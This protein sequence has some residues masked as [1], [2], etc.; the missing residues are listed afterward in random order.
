M[1]S[2]ID[3][4][5]SAKAECSGNAGVSVPSESGNISGGC[6]KSGDYTYKCNL[7][8]GTCKWGAKTLTRDKLEC[9][10]AP[11]Q[12]SAAPTTPD[13]GTAPESSSAPKP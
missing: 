1:G 7:M 4:S 2:T 13:S 11:A 8:P 10:D 12:A 9:A 5:A 3:T 6:V